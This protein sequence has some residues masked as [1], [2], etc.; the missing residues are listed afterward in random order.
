MTHS[1]AIR[2]LIVEFRKGYFLTLMVF[3]ICCF[4][5]GEIDLKLVVISRF[6]GQRY[7]SDWFE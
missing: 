5:I 1:S 4:W 7:P 2:R 3:Y 6:F